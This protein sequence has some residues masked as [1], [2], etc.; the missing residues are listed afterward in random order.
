MPTGV[1][2]AFVW[3]DDSW[4]LKGNQHHISWLQSPVNIKEAKKDGQI[5]VERFT[6][7]QILFVLRHTLW[8]PS[9]QNVSID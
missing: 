5:Y 1:I 3:K 6:T 7:V 4:Y 8:W 2:S 9:N